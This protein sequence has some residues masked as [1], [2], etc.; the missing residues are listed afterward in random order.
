MIEL[1]RRSWTTDDYEIFVSE[2]EN[3]ADPKYREFH[4]R[5]IGNSSLVLGV[6]IPILRAAAK[7]IAKGN[8][9]AFFDIKDSRYF[10]CV[11]LRGLL[12]GYIKLTTEQ[13]F[14]LLN[15]YVAEITDWSLCD[16]VCSGLKQIKKDRATALPFLERY[17]DGSEFEKRTFIVMLIFHYIDEEYLGYILNE[18]EKISGGYYVKMAVAWAVSVCCVKFPAETMHFLKSNQLDDFTFRK[19]I[20]KI[21]DSFRVGAEQKAELRLMRRLN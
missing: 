14:S 20:S 8:F 18:C 9:R 13:L 7:E 6:K 5:L 3:Q 16:S 10:E 4:R 21:C 12:L 1:N 11:M 19:S 2:L 17:R 15:E